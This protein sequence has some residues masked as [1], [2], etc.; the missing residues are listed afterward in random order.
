MLQELL[1]KDLGRIYDEV[2]LMQHSKSFIMY[3]KQA[4]IDK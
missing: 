1:K 3:L 4:I 2:Y